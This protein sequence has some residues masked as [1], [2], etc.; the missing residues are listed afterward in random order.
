MNLAARIALGAA[1]GM[2]GIL[3]FDGRTRP[4]VLTAFVQSGPSAAFR[5]SPWLVQNT[6]SL[7][8]SE[9]PLAASMWMQTAAE[10]IEAGQPL[11]AQERAS[12]VEMA[13]ALANREPDNAFWPQMAA[14]LYADGGDRDSARRLWRT[15]GARTRWDDHQSSRLISTANRAQTPPAVVSWPYARAYKLRSESAPRLIQAYGKT[16]L[17]E[18]PYGSPENVRDRAAT[19]RN[20]L[21]MRDGA[22]SIAIGELGSSLIEA[23]SRDHDSLRSGL[24]PRKLLL[25]RHE[26]IDQLRAN[27]L[28]SDEALARRAFGSNDAWMAFLDRESARRRAEW[29]AVGSI[30]AAAVPSSLL[31]ASAVG[32]AFMLLAA[33]M[34]RTRRWH[35]LL[36]SPWPYV[37]GVLAGIALYAATGVVYASIAVALSIS[38]LALEPPRARTHPSDRLGPAFGFLAVMLAI[39]IGGFGAAHVVSQSTPAV[40]I[41]KSLD[42]VAAYAGKPSLLVVTAIAASLV[43][44]AAPIFAVVHRLHTAFVVERL[45]ARVGRCLLIGFLAAGL[46]SVP[47]SVGIEHRLSDTLSKILLNEPNYYLTQ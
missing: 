26:L 33:A 29:L 22:R 30:L 20:G 45:V 12:A 6:S 32:A 21:L 8:V 14:V 16:V 47:V 44:L 17:G 13:L 34:R 5:T 25:A 31:A 10:R 42:R 38:A 19:L 24:T 35:A 23:S 46:L 39:A 11:S 36:S 41:A 3:L 18:F 9:D 4:V 40:E 7:P 43:M 15:A 37:V 2:A 28:T 27:G 1:V